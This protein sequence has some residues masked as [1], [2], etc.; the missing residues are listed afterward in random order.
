MKE[1]FRTPFKVAALAI[2]AALFVISTSSAPTQA[3]E[4]EPLMDLR[5]G[6]ELFFQEIAPSIAQIFT[7]GSAGSGY[8]IDREGYLITNYHVT[9]SNQNFEIAFY[10]DEE[11]SRA[12]RSGRWQGHLIAEDPALDLAVIKVDAPP[13]R[14]HPVRLGDSALMQPGDTVATFGSPGGDAGWVDRSSI[15]FEDSWL[16]FYNLNLGV[17]AEVFSF[18]EAFWTFRE[19]GFID[20]MNRAG[21]RDYGSAVEYLFHTDSAINHGNSGGP[22]LNIF[23]EA[24]GTNTWGFG[25]ENVGMSVPVNLLKKNVADMIE[26]GRVRRPWCGIS[27]HPARAPQSE[28]NRAMEN[29]A[30]PFTG[31]VWFDTT[32]DVMK[33]HEV[34]PYSPAYDAGLRVGDVIQAVDGV[35]FKNV[36]DVYSYFLGRELG[37]EVRIDF[38]RNGN[39]MPP[40]IVTIDEKKTRYS[41]RIIQAYGSGSWSAEVTR[42]SAEITY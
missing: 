16:E 6:G 40:A 23:G 27:L 31:L 35:V 36:F 7:G 8:V 26:Y 42:Y 41:N 14:F 1:F 12:Y 2:F 37:D 29:E 9:G 28:V 21:V 4:R 39:D 22:C 5:N 33:I 17:I 15:N 11:N 25:G 34:N 32:P 24:I 30:L 20:Y 19:I 18:E 10:G 3:E 13:E 38:T